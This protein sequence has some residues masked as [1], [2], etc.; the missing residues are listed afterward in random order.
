M[1]NTGFA[2]VYKTGLFTEPVLSPPSHPQMGCSL[3]ALQPPQEKCLWGPA[4][5]H[6]LDTQNHPHP[7]HFQSSQ[8]EGKGGWEAQ[9]GAGIVAMPPQYKSYS[10]QRDLGEQVPTE[11]PMKQ[12]GQSFQDQFLAMHSMPPSSRSQMESRGELR[13]SSLPCFLRHTSSKGN[14]R[15]SFPSTGTLH[16]GWPNGADGAGS[17]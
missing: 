5:G 14:L 7:K 10:W 6:Q 16:K 11:G 9:G 4:T 13:A 1:I 15:R 8:Q 2:F 3:P 17:K 12:A